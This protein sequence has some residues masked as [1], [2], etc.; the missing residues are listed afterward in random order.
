MKL[1]GFDY[2]TIALEHGEK[3]V[4]GLIALFAVFALSL[5][6]PWST[7]EKTP[8]EVVTKVRNVRTGI[9]QSQWPLEELNQFV[10]G[11]DPR[12]FQT[13][14]ADARQWEH[15]FA[16]HNVLSEKIKN[17][18]QPVRGD[19]ARSP[20]LAYSIPPTWS[21]RAKDALLERPRLYP[22][23]NVIATHVRMVLAM[24]PAV[25]ADVSPADPKAAP[26]KTLPFRGTGSS[27]RKPKFKVRSKNQ[28]DGTDNSSGNGVPPGGGEDDPPADSNGVPGEEG[29]ETDRTAGQEAEGFHVVAVRGIVPI[30]KQLRAYEKALHLPP[31]QDPRQVIDIFDF[32]L[33]RSV[34]SDGGRTWSNWQPVNVEENAKFLFF[35]VAGFETDLVQRGV[36]HPVITSP[37]PSRLLLE[38]GDE[39]TH[40]DITNY[41]LSPEG[42]EKQRQLDELIAR[43][44]EQLRQGKRERQ[45][46]GFSSVVRDL[47]G[48]AQDIMDDPNAKQEFDRSLQSQFNPQGKDPTANQKIEKMRQQITAV[49]DLLLFRYFDFDVLPGLSYRYRVRLKLRNPLY[50]QLVDKVNPDFQKDVNEEFLYTPNSTPMYAPDD[51]Q[52]QHPLNQVTIPTDVHVFVRRVDQRR[53][54]R[55]DE[56]EITM[57]VFQW[58]KKPGTTIAG[59]LKKLHPGQFIAGEDPKT[60]VLDPG[61]QSLAKDTPTR[62]LQDEKGKHTRK[63]VVLDAR[64]G[65]RGLGTQHLKELGLLRRGVR[66]SVP[67][68]VVV[69]DEHGELKKLD[70]VSQKPQQRIL[71]EEQDLIAKAF[72]NWEK[73]TD[74]GKSEMGDGDGTRD[75]SEFDMMDDTGAD[76]PPE[77]RRTRRRKSRSSSIK[78]KSYGGRR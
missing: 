49:G 30:R 68:E 19:I 67:D 51:K 2:K 52:K 53:T 9:A 58:F 27:S 46:G 42:R 7:Y 47:G 14:L 18:L 31:G 32:V 22:V 6:T 35:R 62:F 37:L 76:G 60:M 15:Y 21:L 50:Q 59:V 78:R 24:K 70:P 3:I 10:P 40:P 73:K 56:P 4:L 39:A 23:Q 5:K 72:K 43:Q 71:E 28:G 38:W 11:V 75:A 77:G 66:L 64:N 25:S 48:E 44:A 61:K 41:V 26:Q 54:L 69:V 13:L 1:Q 8:Q 34:S 63:L 33:E 74:S 45:A 57:Q 16:T 36:T 20:G 12:Q 29:G 65:F 17:M 55:L